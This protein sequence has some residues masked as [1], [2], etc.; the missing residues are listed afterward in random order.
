MKGLPVR[1]QNVA[2]SAGPSGDGVSILQG[3]QLV[4][5]PVE[6][7]RDMNGAKRHQMLFDSEEEWWRASCDI[8]TGA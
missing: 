1:V 6:Q 2:K 3:A 7:A 4:G 8:A 5:C